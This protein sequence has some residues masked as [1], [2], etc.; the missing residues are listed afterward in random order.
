MKTM[1]KVLGTILVLV[2]AGALLASC[3]PLFNKLVPEEHQPAVLAEIDA[4]AARGEITAAQRDAIIEALMT[5]EFDWQTL[6]I[7]LG[8]L[9]VTAYTGKRWAVG[10]VRQERGA[11]TQKAGLPPEQVESV[12]RMV[13]ER[14][15][16]VEPRATG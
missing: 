4:M 6:L 11:P 3:E 16:P 2:F 13:V 8:G 10:A 15:K 14:L 5:Q 9:A 12:A 1:K 7:S